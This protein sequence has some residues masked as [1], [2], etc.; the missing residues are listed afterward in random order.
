MKKL[1]LLSIFVLGLVFGSCITPAG[2]NSRGGQQPPKSKT[3]K[4]YSS[5][6][7]VKR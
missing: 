2:L 6:G 3:L 1:I 5:T 4:I 7:L